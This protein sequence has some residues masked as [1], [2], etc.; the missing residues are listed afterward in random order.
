MNE[1]TNYD[2]AFAFIN[3]IED[4]VVRNL[5]MHAYGILVFQIAPYDIKGGFDLL[6]FA[7]VMEVFLRDR[8][9]IALGEESGEIETSG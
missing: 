3:T 8:A 4:S 1:I 7:K 2:E 9:A 6:L 5:I